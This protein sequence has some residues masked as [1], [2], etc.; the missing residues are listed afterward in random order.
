MKK[1]SKYNI[2]RCWHE[3]NNNN[4]HNNENDGIIQLCQYSKAARPNGL[5]E[6]GKRAPNWPLMTKGN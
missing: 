4:L 3:L 6:P 5:F 2:T 1:D